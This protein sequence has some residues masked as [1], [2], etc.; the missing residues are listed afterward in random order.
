M[1]KAKKK[2]TSA[3]SDAD[4]II[5]EFLKGKQTKRFVP[6]GFK[7]SEKFQL[8]YKLTAAQNGMSMVELLKESFALWKSHRRK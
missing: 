7:V 8:E 2:R 3:S 6:L 1:P 4:A 5:L